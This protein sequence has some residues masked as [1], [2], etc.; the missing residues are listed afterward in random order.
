[1]D[2]EKIKISLDGGKKAFDEI[3]GIFAEEIKFNHVNWNMT[4]YLT[5]DAS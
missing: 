3:K 2:V 4:I 5:K 1:M